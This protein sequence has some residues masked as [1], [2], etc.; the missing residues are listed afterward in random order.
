VPFV[1]GILLMLALWIRDNVPTRADLAWV[2]HAGGLIKPRGSLHPETERFN[3]SQKGIFWAVVLGSALMAATGYLMLTPFSLTGVSGMQILHVVH[4][5]LAVLLI[6]VILGHIF[7]GM[8]GSFDAM[9]RGEVNENWAIEH[10]R[11]WYGGQRRAAR[12]GG[13]APSGSLELTE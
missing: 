4:A 12:P 2:R 3:A 5:L 8:Q 6:V 1:L 9:C 7:I 13:S 10:H 11:G